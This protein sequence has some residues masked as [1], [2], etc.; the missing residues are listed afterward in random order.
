MDDYLRRYD[1][2][3]ALFRRVDLVILRHQQEIF[4][5]QGGDY[6]GLNTRIDREVHIRVGK[7]VKFSGYP[8][9]E[10]DKRAV[11]IKSIY[12]DEFEEEGESDNE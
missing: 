2:P 9:I 1:N 6:D 8:G 10:N 3:S 4:E 11:K 12:N 5:P 7:R